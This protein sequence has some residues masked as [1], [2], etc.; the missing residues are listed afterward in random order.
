MTFYNYHGTPSSATISPQ[1]IQSLLP[2]F[3]IKRMRKGVRMKI[4]NQ[5]HKNSQL[6]FSQVI[7]SVK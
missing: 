3:T 1:S 7:K 2:R 5:E 6:S 4:S